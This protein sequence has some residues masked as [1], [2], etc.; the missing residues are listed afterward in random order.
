MEVFSS[1]AKVSQ[2][3]GGSSIDPHWGLG[4]ALGI[5]MG[6]Y[7]TALSGHTHELPIFFRIVSHSVPEA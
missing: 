3:E 4:A 2:L 6:S 7:C 1:M 5:L